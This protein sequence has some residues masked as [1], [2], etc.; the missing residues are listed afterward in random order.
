MANT[1]SGPLGHSLA[2]HDLWALRVTLLLFVCVPFNDRV[3]AA[4]DIGSLF[5][6]AGNVRIPEI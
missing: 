6:L 5:P 1:H 3:D 2:I 4:R